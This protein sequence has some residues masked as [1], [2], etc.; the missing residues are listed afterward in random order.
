MEKV[1]VR[2]H[3]LRADLEVLA[4]LFSDGR[5]AG[6][7]PVDVIRLARLQVELIRKRIDAGIYDHRDIRPD[8]RPSLN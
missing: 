1:P 8:V 4:R 2:R 5:A 3:S 6:Y 7:H